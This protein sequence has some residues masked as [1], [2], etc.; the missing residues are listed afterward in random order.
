QS[1]EPAWLYADRLKPDLRD[2]MVNHIIVPM[3]Q[4]AE[5]Q[6]LKDNL[7]LEDVYRKGIADLER[8]DQIDEGTFFY[9]WFKAVARKC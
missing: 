2:G 6:I 3:V 9:T 8:V 1:C 5:R 7:V 4:S